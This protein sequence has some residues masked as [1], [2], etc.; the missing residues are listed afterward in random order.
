MA[1]PP[2][3]ILTA[4]RRIQRFMRL[5]DVPVQWRLESIWDTMLKGFVM[6]N[7]VDGEAFTTFSDNSIY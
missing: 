7:L 4:F 3:R 5:Q 1:N 2:I 6:A